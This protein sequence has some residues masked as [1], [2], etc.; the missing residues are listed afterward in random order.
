MDLDISVLAGDYLW[1]H[2]AIS[3]ET[4]M[5]EKTVCN[6]S[7]YLRE[8]VHDHMSQGCN[9]VFNRVSEE[10]SQDVEPDDLLLP[11][12]LS[13]STSAAEQ[14]RPKG[15][16]AKIHAAFAAVYTD[17]QV[18]RRGTSGDPCLEGRIFTY[19]NR[20]EVQKAIHANT[21]HL[22]FHWDFCNG[23]LSS[24]F[25]FNNRSIWVENC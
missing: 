23:S 14:F 10:I 8:Y 3:D 18:P 13:S 11:Q 2:G 21:T 12:C 22:P 15:K 5:L 24:F 7:Q 20:P 1:S 4:L 9:D 19:L 6:D 17:G 25:F 16:H